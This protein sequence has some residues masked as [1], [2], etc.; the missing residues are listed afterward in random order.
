MNSP[1]K[2]RIFGIMMLGI[3]LALTAIGVSYYQFSEQVANTERMERAGEISGTLDQ[4]FARV[5]RASNQ[6]RSYVLSSDP[7]LL[8]EYE[9]AVG[10]IPG[11]MSK[12]KQL[13][14]DN[15]QQLDL[16]A[17][18]ETALKSKL[19]YQA[20]IL[21]AFRQS[22]YTGVRELL[23]SDAGSDRLEAFR[24]EVS[25]VRASEYRVATRYL[26]E[27]RDGLILQLGLLLSLV[28]CGGIWTS[29]LSATAIR[30]ILT[31]VRGM[32]NH[33]NRIAAGD[34]VGE[35]PVPRNDEI[36]ALAVHINVMTRKVNEARAARETART[37]LAAERQNLVDAVEALTDGFAA[38]DANELLVHA[39]QKYGEMYPEIADIAVRGVSL[40]A[41]LLQRAEFGRE[42]EA[43][44]RERD[45]VKER[46]ADFRDPGRPSEYGMGN[47]MII[48]K[49]EQRT[50]NG[51]TVGVYADI[52]Q[53]KKA[54]ADLHS[55]NAE[56]DLRV[57]E[58]TN[59]LDKA[60]QQL[61]RLNAE[62]ST[63]IRSAPVAIMALDTDGIVTIWNPAAERLTGFA[64][65]AGR[66]ALAE[67]AAPETA[68]TLQGLLAQVYSGENIENI[69]LELRRRDGTPI[70]A[71]ISAAGLWD[72]R[73][74]LHGAIFTV[75]DLTE[76]RALQE[77]FQQSQKMEVVAELT[78]GVAHDFNNLLGII[79]SNLDML[80][81]R[82]PKRGLAPELVSAALRASL[83]GVALN[84]QLLAFSRRQTLRP[85]NV[86]I[87][88][89]IAG[90]KTLLSPIL[91]EHIKCA[92]D[93]T[94]GLWPAMIDPT[95]FES[96]ILNLAVNSRDAM[97]HGGHLMISAAN[98]LVAPGVKGE[99]EK[100]SGECLAITVSDTGDGMP[101]DVTARAFEPF[102]TT[103]DFGKGS[104]LG[105]SMVYG[106]VR[107]SGGSIRIESA[108]GKGTAIHILLPR[109]KGAAMATESKRTSHDHRG[110]G[111]T[112]LVV[113]DNDALRRA[114][115]L[116]LQHLGYETVEA[117][118][119]KPALKILGSKANVDLM[120]T[121]IVMPGGRDGRALASEALKIRSKLPVVFMS[122]FPA[123][124]DGNLPDGWIEQDA[125]VLLKPVRSRD[126]AERIHQGLS[127]N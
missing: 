44:G 115:V 127:G 30:G 34:D 80:E 15:P 65:P 11:L 13:T 73:N 71:N 106:F 45:W 22:G 74:N 46:L 125:G 75:V 6:N 82:V 66:V 31:P 116:Q 35:L 78:A 23:I 99:P 17:K 111:Q 103:K 102:F 3:P 26:G 16:V 38:F 87:Q 55:L 51:G 94:P 91:G 105:L 76:A 114:V 53:L 98:T 5:L 48:R 25:A 2:F 39:N 83:S 107:Q 92:I 54:E 62:L 124:A 20:T 37:A 56:L 18:L 12:V 79:I 81:S 49:S 109:A 24:T 110:I 123:A 67:L 36:G 8:R 96:A 10:D 101:P 68:E 104:G 4:L 69:E 52:S 61:E 9:K 119:A 40:E 97:P 113:E 21:T 47:G 77:Q 95:L 108:S 70:T 89:T 59:E 60:N 122:G 86:N 120:L 57:T 28:L 85:V 32:I 112:I 50:R 41:L 90:L 88:E 43:R 7:A 42:I 72:G 58:R 118:S 84:R 121:D 27:F 100:L 117:D 33:V 93:V 14:A 19:A 63:L 126:L 29:M 1:L 64:Q